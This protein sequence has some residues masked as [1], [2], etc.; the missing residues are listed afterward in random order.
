M[1]VSENFV[2]RGR[3]LS[4]IAI[5][6]M[7]FLALIGRFYSLQIQQHQK[8]VSQADAN[9][10]REVSHQGPRGLIFDR[11]GSLLV[12]N[13]FT[14]MLSAIPWEIQKS[15]QVLG[16]LS[17]YLNLTNKK[18]QDRLKEGYRG[19][20]VPIR[21]ASGL[22]FPTISR[23]EEHRLEL[24]GV[25]LSNDPIR[26]YASNAS[27]AHVLGYLR[28]IDQRDL[29]KFQR[30]HKYQLG[31]LVGFNGLERQYEDI[32]CGEKGYR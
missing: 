31:D 20:F 13:R 24:P 26:Y 5:V 12:D 16:E 22:T 11:Y 6:V 29:E 2:N 3:Y 9:R 32:L 15:P 23:L 7:L 18:L 8:Y 14:Y 4:L 10:I 1:F 27:L 30:T 21:L 17:Q 19:A 25:I 28:E